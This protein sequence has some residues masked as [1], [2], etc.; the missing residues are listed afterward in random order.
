[1]DGTNAF[2][3]LEGRGKGKREREENARLIIT[4]RAGRVLR[5]R[6]TEIKEILTV[7]EKMQIGGAQSA[8]NYKGER[9]RRESNKP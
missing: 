2:F 3:R 7:G 5:D 4:G 8:E 1:L 6:E 9:H